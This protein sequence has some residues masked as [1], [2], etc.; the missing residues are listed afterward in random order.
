MENLTALTL[1]GLGYT[2]D[3]HNFQPSSAYTSGDHDDRVNQNLHHLSK[4]LKTLELKDW[5]VSPDLFLPS[6]GS[7]S[8]GEDRWRF[9]ESL[10]VSGLGF[11]PDGSWYFT[12]ARAARLV[13]GRLAP[14]GADPSGRLPDHRWRTDAEPRTLNPLME[15]MS[16]A[17]LRMDRLRDVKF[18]LYNGSLRH[19]LFFDYTSVA[20][21]GKAVALE[22]GGEWRITDEILNCWKELG[23]V[24]IRYPCA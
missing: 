2:P 22:F 20:E 12:G 8:D 10:R 11:A 9:L 3:N 6:Q 15:A 21:G 7:G 14:V 19:G 18:Q 5:M 16:K 23:N 13:P 17:L 1:N 4:R 24:A